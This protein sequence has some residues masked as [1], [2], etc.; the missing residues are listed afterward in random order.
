MAYKTFVNGY[1]LSAGELNTYVMPQVI[2]VFADSS[3]RSAA[4]T[5]PTTGQFT[6]LTGT[7]SLEFWN[8]SAWTAFSSGGSAGVSLDPFLLMGA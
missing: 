2:A 6:Y 4:I 5:S 1:N 3:E 8:G 7:A